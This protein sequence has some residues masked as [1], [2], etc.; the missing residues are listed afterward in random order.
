MKEILRCIVLNVNMLNVYLSF[1]VLNKIAVITKLL[2]SAASKAA[3][4]YRHLS[5][6]LQIWSSSP[7]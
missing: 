4:Q 6:N 5:P 7:P 1:C 3:L 2:C